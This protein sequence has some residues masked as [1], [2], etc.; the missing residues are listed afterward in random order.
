VSVGVD[1]PVLAWST[2]W[3]ILGGRVQFLLAGPVVEVGVHHANYCVASTIRSS[4]ANW[5]GTSEEC[6]RPAELAFRNIRY[7]HNRLIRRGTVIMLCERND[8]QA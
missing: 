1:I 4:P 5:P 2:P 6:R 3:T 8:E 7:R